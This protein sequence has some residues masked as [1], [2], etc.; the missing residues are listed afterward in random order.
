M[1]DFLFNQGDLIMFLRQREQQLDHEVLSLERDYLL[2]ASEADLC[3]YFVDKYALDAPSVDIEKKEIVEAT[4]NT[5]DRPGM[6]GDGPERAQGQVIVLAVPFTGDEQLLRYKPSSFVM[7]GIRASVADSE[8]HLSYQH[9]EDNAHRVEPEMSSDLGALKTN[10]AHVAKDVQAY[11]EGLR[12]SIN[13]RVGA[14]KRTLLNQS[15]VVASLNIPVRQRANT[16]QTY[17]VP[18]VKRKVRVE[19]PI[20]PNVPFIPEPALEMEEY[21]YIL[22]VVQNMAIMMERSPATFSQLGEEEI[23]NHFLLHLNGH[24]EGQATGETFNQKG[25]TDILIRANGQNIFIS[26]CK[27]WT[28]GRDFGGIIDSCWAIRVGGIRRLRFLFSTKTKTCRKC[29]NKFPL[30]F[31]HIPTIS[32]IT[33]VS[34]MPRD[35]VTCF[36]MWAIRIGSCT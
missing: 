18:S 13:G 36:T 8:L 33:L 19:R 14:R 7:K 10:V 31:K 26:E 28:G 27:F 25:K 21:E 35:F 9:F 1:A 22:N 29:W 30:S 17:A 20:V 11:N 6:W 5:V 3:T 12:A 4:P 2:N 34:L 23:R 32:G 24:Y 16:P 15:S